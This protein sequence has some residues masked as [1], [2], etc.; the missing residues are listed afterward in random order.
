MFR[1]IH[2]AVTTRAEAL[3]DSSV[4]RYIL[5]TGVVLLV[6]VASF[7][8]LIIGFAV[9]YKL[10]TFISYFLTLFAHYFLH[11]KFTF[12]FRPYSLKSGAFYLVLALFNLL[13]SMLVA[14]IVVELLVLNTFYVSLICP[15]VTF[16]SSYIFMRFLVFR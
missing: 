16:V 12:K 1:K 2:F 10:A 7:N 6:S 11:K 15:F 9:E 4:L 8:I 14:L 13:L 5:V 3:I